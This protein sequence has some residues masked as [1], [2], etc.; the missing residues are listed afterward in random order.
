R[1]AG[2]DFFNPVH[3]MDLV[4]V[5]WAPASEGRAVDVLTRFALDLGKTPVR[6]KDSPGFV[7]NRVLMP[8]A[9]EAVLLVA[10][11]L[12]IEQVDGLMRRFG[13]P[14]G[15]LEMLDTVGL[16]VAAHIAAAMQ[17]AFGARYAPN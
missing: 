6:V 8:Y 3:K 14:V 12:G 7:V 5:V 11:G 4:E 13:M 10:E 9:N 16:D 1:V 2:L 15:P 17:P